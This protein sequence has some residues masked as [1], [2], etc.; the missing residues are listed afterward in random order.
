MK[1]RHTVAIDRVPLFLVFAGFYTAHLTSAEF[2]KTSVRSINCAATIFFLQSSVQK[3]R[4]Y[5]A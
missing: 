5:L 1:K 4:V 3:K 2:S